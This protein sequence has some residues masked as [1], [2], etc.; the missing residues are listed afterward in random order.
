MPH[1]LSLAALLV[2]AGFAPAADSSKFEVEVKKDVAYRTDKEADKERHILDVY[3]PKGK[4][5]YPVLFFVHGGSWK[6]GNKRVFTEPAKRFAEAGIG[7]VSTNYRLTP[8]VKHPG[9]IEDV[10]M[11]FAWTVDH[12]GEYGGDAKKIVVSGH[13]AGGH[14][15]ALLATNETYLKAEKKSF[16]DIRGV[17]GVSG[18]YMI[19]PR[20]KTLNDAFG[21]DEAVCKTASPIS[22]VAGTHPPMSLV[23]GDND[24]AM[25]DKG[26]ELFAAALTKEKQTASAKEFKDRTH[27]T[28]LTNMKSAD[29]P[30]FLAAKEFVLKQTAK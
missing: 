14:L 21:T 26:A 13:S 2:F 29:D 10:A 25:L 12:I 7:V 11:A 23:Y 17:F 19:S 18:V 20:A 4:K 27:T 6:Q 5:D 15:A 16:A 28:I 30:V 24:L 22:H 3:I 9:H 8:A 1:R